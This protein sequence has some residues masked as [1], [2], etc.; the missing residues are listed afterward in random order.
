M[1]PTEAE[2]GE[3]PRLFAYPYGEYDPSLAAL[4]RDRGFVGFGQESGGVYSGSDRRLLPRFPMA[5]AFAGLDQFKTKVNTLAM[6]VT[7]VS[8]WDP[9]VPG[10]G[11]PALELTVA[12][13]DLRLAQLRCYASGQGQAPVTW[14]ARDAGRFRVQAKQPLSGRRAR[15]NCTA[16][17]ATTGRFYWFSHLW[18][19]PQRPED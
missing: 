18:I 1:A 5:E 3:A 7:E 19:D 17:S 6:P 12:P 13:G 4:I 15:Y 16:P 9:V 10:M 2:L 11:R 8:P 14:L